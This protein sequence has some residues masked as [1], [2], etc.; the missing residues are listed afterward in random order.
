[1]KQCSKKGFTIV[2]L[3]AAMVVLA[4]AALVLTVMMG[5]AWR[6]RT[7][8][9]SWQNSNAQL[10]S[11]SAQRAG[12]PATLTLRGGKTLTTPD[13]VGSYMAVEGLV[14]AWAYYPKTMDWSTLT[15]SGA[16]AQARPAAG[17]GDPLALA[18]PSEPTLQKLSFSSSASTDAG[19]YNYGAAVGVSELLVDQHASVVLRQ[20]FLYLAGDVSSAYA[21][22]GAPGSLT[23]APKSGNGQPLLVYVANPLKVSRIVK[24]QGET[25]WIWQ[26]GWYAV[27]AGTDLFS[28]T[29]GEAE[30]QTWRLD[31]T[32]ITRADGSHPASN[33][34]LRPSE[35]SEL[36]EKLDKAYARLV[37]AGVALPA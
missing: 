2:E 36:E 23:A 9:G 33:S 32:G 22:G 16:G 17:A 28:S 5:A 19:A 37:L 15:E 24:E 7:E 25:F 4:F 26:P 1:M 18:A 3:V 35:R 13:G 29:L 31:Y 27:P 14:T 21:Q 20:E 34:D 10:G 30:A 11:Y 8:A 6:L 12:Y